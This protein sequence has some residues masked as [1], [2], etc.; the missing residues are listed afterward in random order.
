MTAEFERNSAQ[1][2][3][4]IRKRALGCVAAAM[5]LALASGCASSGPTVKGNKVAPADVH[6]YESTDLLRTQYTL[7]QHVWIDSWRTNLT[8][9][10]FRSEADGVD[11]MKRIASDSGANAL[12][13][14]ICLD[15]RTGSASGPVLYCYG[16][17]IRVN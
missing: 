3:R 12:I 17:A 8:Y 5:L 15:G 4:T 14:V 16:D 11:A 10:T 2:R 13:H 1:S 7:V 6:V 9:P